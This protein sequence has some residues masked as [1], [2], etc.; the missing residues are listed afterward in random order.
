LLSRLAA[1]PLRRRRSPSA[2]GPQAL[3]RAASFVTQRGAKAS[4]S[5]TSGTVRPRAKS[6]IARKCRAAVASRAAR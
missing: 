6:Q 4:T 1:L 2:A 3:W 5:E